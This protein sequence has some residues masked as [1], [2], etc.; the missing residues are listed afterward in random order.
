MA[1]GTLYP[2]FFIHPVWRPSFIVIVFN[3]I[4]SPAY[5]LLRPI[6]EL[7]RLAAAW[8]HTQQVASNRAQSR[9]IAEDFSITTQTPHSIIEGLLRVTL[10]AVEHEVMKIKYKNEK[11]PVDD[12]KCTCSKEN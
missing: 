1:S 3:A 8:L 5:R 9:F 12:V 6:V 11:L 4:P 2:M 10:T 7:D